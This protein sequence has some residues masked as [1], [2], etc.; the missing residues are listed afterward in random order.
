MVPHYRA[1]AKKRDIEEPAIYSAIKRL[2]RPVMR[3]EPP[4]PDLLCE[5]FKHRL[6]FL[7]VKSAKG[8][9]TP[10]QE[11]FIR[12]WGSHVVVVRSVEEAIAALRS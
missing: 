9:L 11:K 8:K 4:L 3:L 5:T 6:V 7:E 2:G 12:E 1:R 10:S